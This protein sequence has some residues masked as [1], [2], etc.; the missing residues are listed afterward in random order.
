MQNF[1]LTRLDSS[2]IFSVKRAFTIIELLVCIAIIGLLVSL[3]MPAVSSAREAARRVTCQSDVRQLAFA[4]VRC[5]DT[6]K[7]FPSNGGYQP[8]CTVKSTTG[9]DVVISTDDF[10]VGFLFKWGVGKPIASINNQP[11]SWAYTVL[12]FIDENNAHQNVL[13]KIKQPLYLCP[14]RGRHNVAVPVD[15]NYGNYESGGWAWAK[16]DYAANSRICPNF[17]FNL[18]SAGVTD[19]LSKTYMLGEKAFDPSVQRATSWY[20]DEPIFSGGSKGTARSG[21]TIVNDGVDISFKENW[22][23]AHRDGANFTT[24]DGTVLFVSDA[25]DWQVMRAMLSPNEGEYERYES[26]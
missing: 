20:W 13:F 19:G 6:Y 22:G 21:L 12:P 25:I 3:T 8:G 10:D 7:Y 1:P 9:N 11:G 17:P 24:C 23:S 15:D 14:S 2:R 5:V 16:T 26:Q 4:M 18:H